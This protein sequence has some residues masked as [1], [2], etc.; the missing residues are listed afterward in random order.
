MYRMEN[1]GMPGKTKGK[2]ALLMAGIVAASA[3]MTLFTGVSHHKTG[4]IR[5]VASFYPVYIAALNLTDGMEG[6]AVESLTQ[7]QTG[8]LHDFQLSPENMIALTG[9]DVLLINGAGA[10]AFLDQVAA[11]LPDLPV[12]DSSQGIELLPAGHVHEHDEEEEEDDD[13]VHTFYNEHI[14][15]SPQRYRKQVENL[16]DGLI[17]LDPAHAADYEANAAVYLA[18]VDAAAERLQSA[19]R[20]AATRACV[21]FHDSLQY[22]ARDLGLTPVAAL[23]MGEEAGVSAADLAVA[24]QA[25]AAADKVLLLYDSQYP[26]E[27]AYVG[28]GASWSRTL[29]LDMGVTGKTDKDAWLQAM[30]GNAQALEAAFG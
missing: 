22:F 16:R 12:V 2:I 26:V 11:Q 7:P 4:G 19:V 5:V 14:W 17:R 13:H 6:V 25:A 8:C 1:D 10:E 20:E 28:D 27:Y 30:E 9:A 3:I 24:Q 18:K 23:T 15:A 29:S 21:T